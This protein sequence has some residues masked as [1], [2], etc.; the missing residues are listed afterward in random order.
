VPQQVIPVRIVLE[1]RTAA[2]VVGVLFV[3]IGLVWVG[4]G[5]GFLK[6]SIMTGNMMWTWIGIAIAIV[7]AALALVG[8]RRPAR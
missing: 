6:G 2:T 3:L 7:G 4:Q 8:I 5:L 1:M